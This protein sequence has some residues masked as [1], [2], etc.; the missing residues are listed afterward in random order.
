MLKSWKLFC[1]LYLYCWVK[2]WEEGRV[3]G[4][5]EGRSNVVDIF[6][7]FSPFSLSRWSLLPL[8]LVKIFIP[9][10]FFHCFTVS[11]VL[12]K[13][14]IYL[15]CFAVLLLWGLKLPHRLW[16]HHISHILCL[17]HVCAPKPSAFSPHRWAPDPSHPNAE[18]WVLLS[19][20]NLLLFLFSFPF[21]LSPSLSL[22]HSVFFFVSPSRW[23]VPP[24][25]HSPGDALIPN[26]S[27]LDTCHLHRTVLSTLAL[28]SR[29]WHLHNTQQC[30]HSSAQHIDKQVSFLNEIQYNI[31]N[32]IQSMR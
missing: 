31:N 22:S 16:K 2:D 27:S 18:C 13:F 6:C 10:F 30:P 20:A 29:D 19:Q 1:F 9:F 17:W 25:I 14:F 3:E 4:W 12:N 11:N 28:D 15:I 21:S 26:S 7:I 32:K 24:F 5:V 8:S 23:F